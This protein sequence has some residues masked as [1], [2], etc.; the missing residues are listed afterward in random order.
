MIIFKIIA[1]ILFIIFTPIYLFI[2][3][4]KFV[5]NYGTYEYYL[6]DIFEQYIYVWERMWE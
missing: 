1:S 3:F 4:I 2:E 6:Y 5:F